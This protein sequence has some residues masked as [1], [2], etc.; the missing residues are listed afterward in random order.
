MFRVERYAVSFAV[1][2]ATPAQMVV[3]QI[4]GAV[5]MSMPETIASYVLVAVM[6]FLIGLILA[7]WVW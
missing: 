4:L 5:A 7:P 1:L 3:R 2:V 6:S